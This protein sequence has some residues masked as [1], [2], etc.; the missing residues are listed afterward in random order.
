MNALM[1]KQAFATLCGLALATLFASSAL[2]Q[3]STTLAAFSQPG[4][5]SVQVSS[6]SGYTLY[7]PN[8][9]PSGAPILTWGNG[10]G[11]SPSTY[12]GLLRQWASYG[13]LVV[14]SNSGSTG[15]GSQ[16]VQGITVIQN[17]GLGAGNYVCTAG[18][19]QGGSGTVNAARDSRVDCAMPIQP[20]TVYT[21]SSHGSSMNGKRS[22][23][24][25]G[26]SDTLA[27]CG[28]T[29]ATYNGNG[30]FNETS[31]PSVVVIRTGAGHFEPTGSGVNDF[32]GISTAFLVANMFNDGS[33]RALFYGPS[34]QILQV[35]GWTN[36][37]FK[38]T[39]GL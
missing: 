5:R 1:R 6:V 12:S 23:I 27:P 31:G 28:S 17:A 22:L 34:P 8:P 39:S 36:E 13:I 14:A 21:A 25:C 26:S 9:I 16:M 32:T 38:G 18:H 11:G 30:L 15:T 4:P 20:D 7:L 3:G 33:A 24:L 37:R 29:F 10:T 35:S 19:S 2:A